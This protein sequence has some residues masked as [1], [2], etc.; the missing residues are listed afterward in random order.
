MLLKVCGIGGESA[1]DDLRMLASAGVDLVGLWYGVN[2]DADLS[3]A[4]LA[5]L[6]A[7]AREHSLEPVLVTLMRDAS[8]LAAALSTSGVSWVQLHGYQLPSVIRQLKASPPSSPLTVVKVLH[9][10]GDSCVE[11]DL[12][13]AY[14]RAGTDAFLFDVASRH[15]RVGST[16]APLQPSAVSSVVGQLDRPFLLAGGISATSRWRHRQLTRHARFAGVDVSSAVRD[17]DGRLQPRQV[18]M[19]RRA[20]PANAEESSDVV[21]H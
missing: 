15:G 14:E 19:V 3:V 2:G 20:W 12:V 4:Q 8:L 21:F 17:S 16:G 5:P 18:Q 10:R 13:R 7:A 6:A 9:I 11:L 1:Q